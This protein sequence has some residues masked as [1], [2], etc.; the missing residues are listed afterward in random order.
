MGSR[1]NVC[2]AGHTT[3]DTKVVDTMQ[4]PLTIYN[5]RK[6]QDF[7]GYCPGQDDV[8]KALELYGVWEGVDWDRLRIT[9]LEPGVVLDFGS[10]IGWYALTLAQQGH[11]VLAFDSDPV[12]CT[13]LEINANR[14]GLEDRIR[15]RNTWVADVEPFDIGMVRFIKSDVEGAEDRVVTICDQIISDQHPM[16]L[17]ECSP[18]FAPYY[19]KMMRD[20]QRRGYLTSIEPHELTSQMNVWFT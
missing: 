14:R 18:E 8:S 3:H 16:M 9:D 4:G 17:M 5:W 11:F 10:H 6:Y 12:N 13:L 2:Q 20:L 19:P 1:L 15:I 7:D